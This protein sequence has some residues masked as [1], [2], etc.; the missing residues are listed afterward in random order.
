[1]RAH[2]KGDGC[3][4]RQEGPRTQCFSEEV[5]GHGDNERYNL[6]HDNYKKKVIL[7]SFYSSAIAK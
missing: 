1:M 5:G 4:A 7:H 6:P 2:K 3:G